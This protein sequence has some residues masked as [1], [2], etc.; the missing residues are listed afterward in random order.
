MQ[1][2]RLGTLL[3]LGHWKEKRMRI[4]L[5]EGRRIRSLR[6]IEEKRKREREKE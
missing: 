2:R 4:I 5:H 3:E 6:A 1:E